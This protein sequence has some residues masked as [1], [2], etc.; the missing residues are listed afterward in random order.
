[1]RSL[2]KNHKV[3]A[4]V[5]LLLLVSVFVFASYT[6]LGLKASNDSSDTNKEANRETVPEIVLAC[7]GRIEGASEVIN[8]GAGADGVIAEIRV[9]EGQ[10]VRA[11]DVLAVIDR[12]DLDAELKR[13]EHR[14]RRTAGGADRSRQPR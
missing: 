13:R 3:A 4:I 14:L 10:A 2:I 8:V 7:P 12:R 9:F 6:R 1:M 11:G 5:V